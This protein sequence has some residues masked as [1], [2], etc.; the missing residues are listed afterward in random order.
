M[1]SNLLSRIFSNRRVRI[2]IVT[3]VVST[4]VFGYFA[5]RALPAGPSIAAKASVPVNGGFERIYLGSGYYV[6][7]GPNGAIL[8]EPPSLLSGKA[9]AASSAAEFSI[10]RLDIGAGY[11]LETNASGSKI[12][13]PAALPA[14]VVYTQKLDIGAGYVLETSASG[15][16]IVAP[17]ALP[18]AAI[19][20]QRLDIGAGYVLETNASG[21]RLIPPSVP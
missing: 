8:H 21:G 14:V 9:P 12:V 17:A 7:Y 5:F 1:K 16:K 11:V 15:S 19:Y 2:A 18:A 20:T 4:F 10:K 3:V 6:E 13:A